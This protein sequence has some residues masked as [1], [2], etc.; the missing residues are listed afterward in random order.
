MH[1][2]ISVYDKK[3]SVYQ[4]PQSFPNLATAMRAYTLVQ[5]QNPAS[6]LIQFPDDFDLYAVG[7]FDEVSGELQVVNPPQFLEH[8]TTL[9]Q[10]Q[11]QTEEIKNGKR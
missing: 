6:P 8:M 4:E 2:L 11:H 5:R 9:V 1:L 3:A 10:K 7:H